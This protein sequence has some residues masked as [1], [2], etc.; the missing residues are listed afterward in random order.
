[1]GHSYFQNTKDIQ[2]YQ[3]AVDKGNFA[4]LRGCLLS[5][6]DVRRQWV[7]QSLMCQFRLSPE[8]YAAR[9][10]E[11]FLQKFALEWEQMAPFCDEGILQ[12]TPSGLEVTETGRLF[13]RNVAMVF[14]A[15]LKD[16]PGT[17]SRTV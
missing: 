16:K 3:S 17:Y 7:I 2:E 15:Y 4:S 1:V 12:P 13:V 9:F 11:D 6:D 10:K 14:D 5:E 8:E